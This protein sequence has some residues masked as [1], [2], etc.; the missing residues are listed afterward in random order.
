MSRVTFEGRRYPRA[1]NESVLDAL[2]RGGARVAFSCRKGTCHT[3]ALR[4]LEGDAGRESQADLRPALSARGYFLPCRAKPRGELLVARPDPTETLVRMHVHANERV[5]PDIARVLLEPELSFG[6]RP[7][8]FVNVI[9]PDQTSRSY[10]I[11]SLQLADYFLELHVRRVPDGKVSRWLADEVRPG[12]V[13]EIQGPHGE[14]TWDPTDLDRPLLLM[15]TGTGLAPL[16]GVAREALLGGHRGEI[17]LYHGVRA[18]SALYQDDA[19][20]A[21]AHEHPRFHYVP[22]VSG[23]E[24]PTHAVSGRV[25]DVA[26][27]RHASLDGF[28]VYLA[29]LPQ[30]VDAARHWAFSVGAHREHIRADPFERAA[31]FMPDDAAKLQRL[32]PDEELWQAL[33]HGVRLRAILTEFYGLVY[34]DARLAPFFHNVTIERAIDKQ[35]SF[36]ADVF[37]GSKGYFGLKPFNA[38]HWMVITEEIFD[39][40]ERL[41]EGVMRRHGLAE[42]LIRRWGSVHELFRRE[43]VK[44]TPRGLIIDGVERELEVVTRERLDFACLCDGCGDTMPVGSYGRLNSRTGKLFCE[45]CDARGVG[46]TVRPKAEAE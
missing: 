3:C 28:A 16:I 14:C 34:Q 29:G 21:L 25:T 15:G 27:Q 17:W 18:A 9:H 40:R 20:R 38:H 44:A 4:V 23:P 41:L 26:A 37:S 36:L 32:A 45:R 8:Q 6:W 10:S 11:A 39:Y 12:D 46:S 31:P 33:D 13:L 5:A 7:G 42:H 30:M 35:Y 22:S 24:V 19:L 1:E 2:V 43:L